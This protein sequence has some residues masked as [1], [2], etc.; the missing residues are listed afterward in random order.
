MDTAGNERRYYGKK[1]R[2]FHFDS[3]N[4]DSDRR[5]ADRMRAAEGET[6]KI[7]TCGVTDAD[8]YV[9]VVGA[10]GEFTD[11]CTYEFV[12]PAEDVEVE[13]WIDTSYYDENGMGS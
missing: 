4:P 8:L 13:A 1:S 9:N 7:I 11:Y 5:P 10:S 12:M 6:V 3:D 2:D